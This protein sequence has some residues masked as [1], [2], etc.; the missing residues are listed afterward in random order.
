MTYA[1]WKLPQE[2]RLPRSAHDYSTMNSRYLEENP[3]LIA[4]FDRV[5]VRGKRVLDIGTGFG[6]SALNL[7]RAGADVTAIDLSGNAVRFAARNLALN[8]RERTR[9]IQMD[10]E[11][12]AFADAT[13]DYVFSWGV[14]HHSE[15]TE[16]VVSEIARVLRAR[17]SGLIMVYNKNSLRYW[18]RGLYW[19]IARAKALHRESLDQVQ[20]HF[21]DGYFHT[22]YTPQRLRRLLEAN[23]LT[24]DSLQVTHMNKQYV[25][26][27][28]ARVDDFIKSTIGWLLVVEFTKTKD[29]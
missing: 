26:L 22:H 3:F 12:L 1:D 5:D 13:F 8:G 29:R 21:T 16:R 9:V 19:Q 2:E 11:R 24:A 10:A 28:P 23:S 18:V 20:R 25:P 17:G 4:F 6:S 7:E 27:V 15:Y 14:I